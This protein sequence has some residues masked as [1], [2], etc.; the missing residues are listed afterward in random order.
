MYILVKA[1]VIPRSLFLL[2]ITLY[3]A[4]INLAT[5]VVITFTNDIYINVDWTSRSIPLLT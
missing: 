1:S 4:I 5:S 3:Y 2:L